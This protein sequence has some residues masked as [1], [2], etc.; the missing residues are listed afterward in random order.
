MARVPYVDEPAIAAAPDPAVAYPNLRA[1]VGNNPGVLEAADAFLASVAP[2]SGLSDRQQELVI[3]AVAAE[4][5]SQYLWHHHVQRAR[6]RGVGDAAITGIAHFDAGPFDEGDA[7]LLRYARAVARGRVTDADHRGVAAAVDA[8]TVVGVCV[9]A[10]TAL[11]VA[12][13]AQSLGVDL[14]AE[15]FVGWDPG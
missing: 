3:L 9:V 12:R 6:D 4:L 2:A 13:V 5:S 1:A 14:E 15:A 11:W 10:G 8:G 7:A